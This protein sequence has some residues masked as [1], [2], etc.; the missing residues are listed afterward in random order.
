MHESQQTTV[1]QFFT[2][3][4]NSVPVGRLTLLQER[5]DQGPDSRAGDAAQEAQESGEGACR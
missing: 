2:R 4:G 3:R 5:P 1:P